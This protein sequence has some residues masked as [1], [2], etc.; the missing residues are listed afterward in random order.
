MINFRQIFL[1]IACLVLVWVTPARA[2]PAAA[3]S[4]AALLTSFCA[5]D[6]DK[7]AALGQ[8]VEVVVSPNAQ[9]R[10][11]AGRIVDAIRN[12]ALVCG[13]G[14]HVTIQGSP[15]LDAVSLQPS[16]AATA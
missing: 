10:A 15:A 6:G 1:T 2:A 14:G 11:W 12:G 7:A 4:R 16:V 9:D 13:T 8:L 3:A 5:T